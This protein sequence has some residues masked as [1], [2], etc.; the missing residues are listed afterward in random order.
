MES[1]TPLR[2]L[3]DSVRGVAAADFEG[4]VDDDG[5]GRGLEAEQLGDGHA[6]QIAID[7]G[8]AIEAPVLGVGGDERVD[9]FWSAWA[10]RKRSSAKPRT[11][12][13]T[14]SPAFQKV[15]R[16]WSGVWRPISA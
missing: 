13:S 12:G 2:K 4:L 10:T 6:Q 7:G 3:M 8:H 16:T 5:K 15:A 11:S 9:F 1:R 14:G